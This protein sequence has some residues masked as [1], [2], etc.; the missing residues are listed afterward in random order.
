MDLFDG[1]QS[2]DTDNA[3]LDIDSSEPASTVKVETTIEDDLEALYQQI[4]DVATQRRALK[5]ELAKAFKDKCGFDPSAVD[6]AMGHDNA[7]ERKIA[8][9]LLTSMLGQDARKRIGINAAVAV[10][11]HELNELFMEPID[12]AHNRRYSHYRRDRGSAGIHVKTGK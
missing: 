5:D 8:K 3:R 11:T 9:E 6:E 2:E 10:D 7:D 12:E 1:P 4:F